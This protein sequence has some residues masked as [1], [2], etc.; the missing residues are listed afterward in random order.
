MKLTKV[1]QVKSTAI[2]AVDVELALLCVA[3]F[4]CYYINPHQVPKTD[5]IEILSS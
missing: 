2:K 1:K 4:R 5:G 3:K